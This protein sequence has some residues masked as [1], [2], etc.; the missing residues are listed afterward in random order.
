MGEVDT[1]ATTALDAA[2]DAAASAHQADENASNAMRRAESLEAVNRQLLFEIV[3]SE[4]HGQFRFAD[5]AL[6]DAAA[7]HYPFLPVGRLLRDRYPSL[8]R[9]AAISSPV[10]VVA[11]DSDRTIPVAQSR[12]LAQ[13]FPG[14]AEFL[15]IP[16][17]DHND[18]VL[19]SGD[20]DITVYRK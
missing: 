14:G 19:S 9:A 11:G 5:A 10:L 3:L 7:V 8:D 2:N 18:S 20:G 4:D 12:R 6:P 16:G 15:V 13:A 17:A 1:T